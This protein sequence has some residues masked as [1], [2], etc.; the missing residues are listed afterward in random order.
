M[1]LIL[2]RHAEAEDGAPDAARQLTAKGEKQAQKIA[3]WLKERIEK[4]VRILVSPTVRTQQTAQALNLKFETETEVGVN[5]S[6]RKILQATG[7][8]HTEGTVIVV[9]HQPTLG[10]LAAFFLSGEEADWDI[11]KGAVWWFE[12]QGKGDAAEASLRAVIAPKEV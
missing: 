5:S 1:D 4:P 11:K 10:Q 2:W 3:K 9:G 12:A 8:P 6:P 7:W